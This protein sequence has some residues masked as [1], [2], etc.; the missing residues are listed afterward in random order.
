MKKIIL[1]IVTL[2][3]FA[4]CEKDISACFNTTATMANPGDAITFTDCSKGGGFLDSSDPSDWSWDF[5]D[6]ISGVGSTVDHSFSKVG[7]YTVKLTVKDK[8]GDKTAT[9]TQ[10]I[11][12]TTPTGNVVFWT[13]ASTLSDFQVTIGATMKSMSGW[14]VSAPG[15]GAS[16]FANFNLP[17]GTYTYTAHSPSQNYTLTDSVVITKNGCLKRLLD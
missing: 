15:C 17:V 13:D 11:I 10:T 2:A 8:D 12:V 14:Q 16:E 9:T 5:G 4:S 7:N 6:G 3:F 1:G